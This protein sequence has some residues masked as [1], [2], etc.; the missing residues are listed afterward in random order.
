L[1][2]CGFSREKRDPLQCAICKM[3]TDPNS[4]AVVELLPDI[5][6]WEFRGEAELPICKSLGLILV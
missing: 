6:N 3:C 5:I 1:A 4:G 2:I